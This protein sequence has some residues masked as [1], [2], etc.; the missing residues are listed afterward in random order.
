MGLATQVVTNQIGQAAKPCQNLGGLGFGLTSLFN[1][2]QLAA[3]VVTGAANL[4]QPPKEEGGGLFGGAMNLA[5]N[6]FNGAKDLAN[7]ASNLGNKLMKGASDLGTSAMQIGGQLFNDVC[8]YAKKD[9]LSF[10]LD[11]FQ[12]ALDL[13]GYIPLFG[14]VPDLI[15]AGIH[16]ARGNYAEAAMSAV[17]AIPGVGDVLGG[18][19]KIA[20]RAA[21]ILPT[22]AKVADTLGDGARLL[23]SPAGKAITNTLP[24]VV[25]GGTAGVQALRGDTQGATTTLLN[26]GLPMLGNSGGK[27]L[28]NLAEGLSNPLAQRALTTTARGVSTLGLAAPTLISGM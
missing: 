1:P 15:N 3:N 24:M 2:A 16:V 19:A 9:P 14:A 21:K 25:A 17:A 10:G 8:A 20:S 11:V 6:L 5:G 7:S 23:N 4:A 12:G 22:A 28:G 18:G 13:A 27:A 26:M